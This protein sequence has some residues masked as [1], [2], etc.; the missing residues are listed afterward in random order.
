M[1]LLIEST[2]Q[3]LPSKT[4]ENSVSKLAETLS[5]YS[6]R[7]QIFSIRL[8]VTRSF[9]ALCAAY[10]ASFFKPWENDVLI[11]HLA[12][13][14][15]RGNYKGRW[16]TLQAM[17]EDGIQ[18]P[19]R[20][21]ERFIELRGPNEFYGNLLPRARKLERRLQQK[22]LLEKNNRPVQRTLRHRGYRDKGS[23]RL[24]HEFHGD[25]PV[26]PNRDDRRHLVNHPLLDFPGGESQLP[27]I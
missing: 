13:L 1:K 10:L 26:K 21:Q 11:R 18:S 6:N 20:F 15:Y 27:S 25:P 14:A 23:R 16:I 17:L 4:P 5:Q 24:P 7:F 8:N 9:D 22:D 3:P 19:E 12:Q 2:T